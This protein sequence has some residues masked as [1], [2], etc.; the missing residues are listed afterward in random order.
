MKIT[1]KLLVNALIMILMLVLIGFIGIYG[2][3]ETSKSTDDMYVQRIGPMQDLNQI[4]RLSENSQVNMLSSVI[5][6]DETYISSI[7]SNF[8]AIAQHIDNYE[9][10]ISTEEEAA[11][12]RSFNANWI[13]FERVVQ[14]HLN[15]I[16]N[17]D[18]ESSREEMRGIGMFYEP[19]SEYL[20]ELMQI[21]QEATES[22]YVNTQEVYRLNLF[23][24]AIVFL[25]A[26]VIAIIISVLMGRS[27]GKPLKQVVSHMEKMANGDLTI[28]SPVKKRKDEIGIL[29]MAMS[30]MQANMK[31]VIMD[32]N[33]ASV[34]VNQQSLELNQAAFQMKNG[35]E[36]IA[37]TMEEL[38]QG[39]DVQ[40]N[41]TTLL[42]ETMD[43]YLITV[44][45]TEE[46]TNRSSKHASDVMQLAD[47]GSVAMK[48]SVEQMHTIFK[49][50]KDAVKQV[51]SLNAETSEIYKLVEVIQDI[52]DQTNLLALNAAIEAARAGEHGKGFAV[53][54]DEVRK[55]AEQVSFS[56]NQITTIVDRIQLQSKDVTFSLEAGYKEVGDGAKQIDETGLLFG[57]MN[58]A[59]QNVSTSLKGIVAHLNK[60]SESSMTMNASIEEMASLSEESAAGIE[61]TAASS[62][63]AVRT[64]QGI[65]DAAIH[66]ESLSILLDE[67]VN[68]FKIE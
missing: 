59:Y 20:F 11:L 36:Q 61:Q 65:S 54:A 29:L 38:S 19:A 43:D 32:I 46:E 4:V 1:M 56:V 3:S 10:A 24:M 17:G 53:V 26:T 28:Q 18:F 21:N 68:H 30:E 23:L 34:Q 64:V 2:L 58:G 49:V 44:S 6:E 67:K 8:E 66:L 45:K 48:A 35:S 12:F 41:H 7:R 22:L 62:E 16:E 5:Y 55:L 39:A 25:V 9:S 47:K 51:S 33:N 60:L 42:N 57:Q 13:R 37:M 27:I 50:V 15:M 14:N 52:A 40:A 63:Q 31:S